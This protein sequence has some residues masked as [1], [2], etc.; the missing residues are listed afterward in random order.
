MNEKLKST[1][2]TKQVYICPLKKYS[3]AEINFHQ[4]PF[5]AIL[6]TTQLNKSANLII[7]LYWFPACYRC[8]LSLAINFLAMKFPKG[9]SCFNDKK[10]LYLWSGSNKLFDCHFLPVVERE[11][12]RIR[13]KQDLQFA[14]K[15]LITGWNRILISCPFQGI[16][17]NAIKLVE[18]A[19]LLRLLVII[20]HPLAS[21][22]TGNSWQICYC[23]VTSMLGTLINSDTWSTGFLMR[24]V[25]A[26][27]RAYIRLIPLKSGT[28]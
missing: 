20:C 13:F 19:N 6:I 11:I 17:N 24:I 18:S 2:S 16:D 26:Q 1:I 12:K 3:L 23:S 4:L 27:F 28:V 7:S 14:F 25:H 10:W 21:H 5:Y 9:C 15:K 22:G 8:W